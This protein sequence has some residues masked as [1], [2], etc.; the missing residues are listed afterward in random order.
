MDLPTK[1]LISS[2]IIELVL[3]DEEA[4]LA[5]FFNVITLEFRYLLSQNSYFNVFF[6]GAYAERR[7]ERSYENDFPF[8]FGAGLAFETKAGLFG[9][10]YALGRQQKNPIDFKSAKIH[11]GYV[12]YF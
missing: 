8:G 5:T 12:N 3:F 10:S 1:D 4:I 11:F 2:L 6:D 9:V 7:L